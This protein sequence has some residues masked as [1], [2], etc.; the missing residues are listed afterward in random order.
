[1]AGREP[2]YAVAK[3]IIWPWLTVWFS[4]HIEGSESVPTTGSALIAVNHVSLFDPLAVA[5]AIDR[6]G[7][8]PRF[9]AKSSLFHVPF[10]SWVLRSARQVR[11]D[12]GTSSAPWS[13]DHATSA[14]AD[15]EII[16]IFPEGT[17]SRS[18]DLEPLQPKTGLARL[19][20][21]TGVP[22]IPCATW[23][24]QW[25]WSYHMGFRP[26]PGKDVWVRF[27]SP[28]SFD[29]FRGRQDEPKAWAEIGSLVMDEIEV[30]KAGMQ[31]AKP[32]V[33]RQVRARYLRKVQ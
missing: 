30:L 8:H 33:A 12:R 16:V 10:V 29:G 26:G 27:G 31:A 32:W 5:Y 15:G 21:S 24:G 23:G 11:V 22:V 28:M 17:I 6:L 18:P 7:R 1:M 9:L 25:V 14:L 4:N 2:G 19:A 20:L 13:L 3:A